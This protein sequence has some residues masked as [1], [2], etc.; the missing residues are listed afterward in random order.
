MFTPVYSAKLVN[1]YGYK[2]Y[3]IDDERVYNSEWEKNG[4]KVPFFLS[5][6]DKANSAKYTLTY[7]SGEN[8]DSFEQ[9]I[10][11]TVDTIKV[12]NKEYKPTN[13]NE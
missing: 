8:S 1:D 9:T 6:D 7:F 5:D 2:T 3:Y 4:Y 11:D 13:E 10:S 12:L